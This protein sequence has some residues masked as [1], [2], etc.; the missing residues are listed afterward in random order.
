[1]TIRLATADD[2]AAIANIYAPYVTDSPVSFEL[3]APSEAEMRG[4]IAAGGALYPW[5]VACGA[6]GAVEG[7][8]SASAFRTR[9]AY[10]FTVETSVYLAPDATGRGVGR[11]LYRR[12]LGTIEAQGFAQAVGAV[13][14]PNP[15]SVALHEALGFSHAGTYRDV[16]YKFGKWHSVGLWQRAL[17]RLSGSPEPVK[18]FAEVWSS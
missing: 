13:T 8:A 6:S 17:T 3:E 11:M 1:V 14:L 7:Y 9:P 2:A 4:R 12:L 15:A 16:G 18:P 5:L 10:R